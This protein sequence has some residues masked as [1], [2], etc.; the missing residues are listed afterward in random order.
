MIYEFHHFHIRPL[1]LIENMKYE[2]TPLHYSVS[3]NIYFKLDQVYS[4]RLVKWVEK[5]GS[6]W[7]NCVLG[8]DEL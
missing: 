5:K 3:T 8:D 2:D 6:S 4:A 7:L 1:F